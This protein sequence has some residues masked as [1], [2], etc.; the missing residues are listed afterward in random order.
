MYEEFE[1]LKELCPGFW[2]PH[3]ETAFTWRKF[4]IPLVI[5]QIFSRKF[6]KFQ[7]LLH[8]DKGLYP[9]IQDAKHRVLKYNAQFTTLRFNLLHLTVKTT[10]G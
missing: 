2:Q 1:A 5:K 4:E 3:K 7:V 8:K 9:E 10:V 6:L